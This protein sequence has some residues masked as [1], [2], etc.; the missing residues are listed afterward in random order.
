M[1]FISLSRRGATTGTDRVRQNDV[2]AWAVIGFPVGLLH[3]QAPQRPCPF[4]S[5][6]NPPTG[7]QDKL[8]RLRTNIRLYPVQPYAVSD[9]S[10]IRQA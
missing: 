2:E 10:R 3:G 6:S 7:H 5:Y 1:L 8:D 9:I 4:N